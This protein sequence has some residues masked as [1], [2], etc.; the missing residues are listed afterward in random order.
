MNA[1]IQN[2]VDVLFKGIPNT[3]K[4]QEL[5]EEILSNMNEHF[6]A[7]IAEGKSEN[8]AYTESVSDLGDVDELLKDL[9]PEQEL[10]G[11]ID[12]YRQRRARN[13]S[14]AVM[15]YILSVVCVIIAGSIPEVFGFG[16]EDAFGIAGVVLMLIL[17]AAATGLLIYTHMSM[18]Q[19]VSQYISRPSS[20]VGRGNGSNGKLRNLASFMKIYWC[21]VLIA[22]LGT[23]FSTGAWHLTWIIWVIGAC[24]KNAIF[25]F[26]NTTE[27]EMKDY[28]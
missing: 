13:T 4:A 27:N 28:E 18:P 26:F 17:I 9:E 20:S 14:I 19:D 23:S 7:H 2:Y 16:N 5:K 8:Q 15:L 6:E 25:I 24:V 3:K 22:Y 11:R 10:K 21:I 1:K 12:I